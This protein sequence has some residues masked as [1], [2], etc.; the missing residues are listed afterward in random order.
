MRELPK[1][2]FVAIDPAVTEADLIA[3][4]E[5]KSGKTLYPAQVERLFIDQIA[6]ATTGMQ[7]SIQ[8]AGEQLLAR[9]SDGPILDHLGELVATPRLLAVAARC[10][11]R[12]AT[13]VVATQPLLIPVGTQVATQDAR[14]SF[15]TDEDVLVP[16]GQSQVSVTAT[17]S[18][19]GEIGNGWAI[20]QINVITNPPL[21]DLVASNITVS[22]D[23]AEDEG[24]DRYRERI[25]LAPEAYSNAGSRGAYRYHAMAVHQSIIDVAVHGPAEGQQPGHVALFPLTASGLPSA[26]LLQRVLTLVSGEKIRPLCDTV[27]AWPPTQVNYA[28]SARIVFF[29]SADR[30][31]TMALVQAAADAYVLELSAALGV[32]I[33]PEQLIARLQVPGVYRAFVELPAAPRELLGSEW[34]V[35]SS[36]QL[37]DAGTSN[38]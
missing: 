29:N 18:S 25:I 9:H 35:C 33:V 21:T 8:N 3:R 7:M 34:A 6:Y 2:V 19:V 1:P 20:G 23:G 32:D 16:V 4:Y 12:F 24:D 14:L 38:G 15:L 5:A 11:L 36:I 22:A 13:A 10:T 28:I 30:V 31:T 27:H 26:D 17:C 37:V